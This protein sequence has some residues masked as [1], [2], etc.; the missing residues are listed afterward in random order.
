MS[1]VR[2]SVRQFVI[3][4]FLFG[5]SADLQDDEQ[6]FLDAGIIDSTGVLELVGFLES[7]YGIRISDQ[8]LLPDNLDSISKIA[9]FVERKSEAVGEARV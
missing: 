3:D 4:T 1:E 6:S 5:Q 8:D 7:Q 2:S 9:R